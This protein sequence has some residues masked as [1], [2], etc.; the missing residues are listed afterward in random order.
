MYR[1]AHRLAQRFGADR[2]GLA[3]LDMRLG[4]LR[5]DQPDR[6]AHAAKQ[7]GPMMRRPARLNADNSG[8]QPLEERHHLPPA[9]RFAQRRP[10]GTIDPMQLEDALRR[11]HANATKPVHGRLPRVGSRHPNLGTSMP[12][13]GRPLQQAIQHEAL[14]TRLWIAA[15]L[16]SSQ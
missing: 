6:M 9:Q 13:R 8:R 7:A 12:I 16:R 10:L 4:E 15:S 2:V 14:D 3:A 11:I 5:R 1:P